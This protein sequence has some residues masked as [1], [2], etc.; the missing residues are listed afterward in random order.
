MTKLQLLLLEVH[1]TAELEGCANAFVRNA[2]GDAR[3]RVETRTGVVPEQL[4]YP[5]KKA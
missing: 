1:A 2:K 4:L 5:V 3:I